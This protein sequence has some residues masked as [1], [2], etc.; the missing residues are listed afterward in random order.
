[1]PEPKAV[2]E[3]PA[4]LGEGPVWVEGENAVYWVD[5]FSHQVHRYALADGAQAE[6]DL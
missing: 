6:L 5:I 3:I 2:W 1:M 4:L